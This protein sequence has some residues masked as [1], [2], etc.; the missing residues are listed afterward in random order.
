MLEVRNAM[1]RLLASALEGAH[2]IGE[3]PVTRTR[4]QVSEASAV[5]DISACSS[6]YVRNT[7]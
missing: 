2:D 7:G 4:E 3:M 6:R 5:P 1:T